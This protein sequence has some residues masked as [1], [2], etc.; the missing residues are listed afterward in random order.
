LEPASWVGLAEHLVEQAGR[1]D[2]R[3][4]MWLNRTVTKHRTDVEGL[5]PLLRAALAGEDPTAERVRR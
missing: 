3:H 4:V 1:S 2:D 5:V